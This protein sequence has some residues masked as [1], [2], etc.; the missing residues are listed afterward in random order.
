MKAY[1]VLCEAFI[2]SLYKMQVNFSLTGID[3][4]KMSEHYCHS[5]FT[6]RMTLTKNPDCIAKRD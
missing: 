4:Q 6:F 1:C 3:I 5:G 2:E